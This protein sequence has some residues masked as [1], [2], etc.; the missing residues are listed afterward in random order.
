M[1]VRILLIVSDKETQSRVEAAFEKLDVALDVALGQHSFWDQVS[2]SPAEMIVVAFDRLPA[3]ASDA[4][5]DIRGLPDNPAVVVLTND[6]DAEQRAS[7]LASGSYAVLNTSISDGSMR[8]ALSS[9]VD[10]RR[11]EV[12]ELVQT[13]VDEREAHLRDFETK[14]PLMQ[15]FMRMVRRV[16]HADSSLL[17]LGETGVGKE[18]LAR[19]IHDASPRS[20]GPFI[21][22][23]CAAFPEALLEGE[24]F[25]FEEGAFTGATGDRRGYFEL[26]HGGTI[27]LDEIGEVPRYVQV[28]L[29]RVLQERCI[30]RLGSEESIPID[31]RIMA[32]TNR[33]LEEE[34]KSRRFRRDL[35]YRLSVV[36]LDVPSL[37]EHPEDIPEL[38]DRYLDEFRVSLRRN[39]TGF[40]PNAVEALCQYP[41][42]GNVRELI[43]VVERAVLLCESNEV[44]LDDLPKTLG[45]TTTQSIAQPNKAADHQDNS[46]PD[47][48]EDKPWSELRRTMLGNLEKTYLT[49]RLTV[50]GGNIGETARQAGISPR[51]LHLMMKRH[52][53]KKEDFRKR[54]NQ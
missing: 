53:L 28:K 34:I 47:D 8:D 12:N 40:T 23:N 44:T 3:P 35:Y 1:L 18:R 32:A 36:T 52:N 15:S 22:V 14:S 4:L 19:A 37:R 11:Q 43:N 39:V 17:I 29:L 5:V 10:R 16:V 38:L 48:W 9:L 51:S 54:R 50:A 21:P 6:E 26:A 24:L 25:G 46:F 27:F 2:Q 49:Q 41:W 7:L 31:V 20:E 42:P 30:Q 45:T 13:E 33:E